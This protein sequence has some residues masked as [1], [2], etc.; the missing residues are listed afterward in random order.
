MIRNNFKIARRN[1]WK[2]KPSTFINLVGLTVGITSCLLIALFIQHE[3]SY[4]SFQPNA[5]RIARLVM[6]Y[7][8]EGSPETEIGT[9]TSTKV[10]PVFSRTF[11]EVEKGIRM[12][13]SSPIV[14]LK[15]EPVTEPGFLYVDST[16]FDAFYY[17]L[18]QGNS[19]TALDGPKKVLLTESMAVKYF[20]DEN[21]IG[22][23]LELGEK[24]TP[25]EI[26]GIL[27][28]YP[29]NS[30]FRFDF[31]ASFSSLNANQ[32]ATYFNANYTTYLLLQ[33]ESSFATLEEKIPAFMAKETAGSGTTI[34]FYLEHFDRVH[35]HSPYNDLVP[36]TSIRYLM[37]L[38]SVALLILIIVCA[39]YINL[40]TA[41][42]MERAKEVGVRKVSGAV[43]SQLFWQFIGESLLLSL[44]AVLVSFGLVYLLLPFFNAFLQKDLL[45]TSLLTPS[46][47]GFSLVVIGAISLAAGGYPALILSRLQPSH[48]LKGAF[49]N[50][51]T[52]KWLQQS[53]TVFQFSI[54]VFLIVTTLIV[55]SQLEFIQSKDLGYDRSH[56]LSI[57]IGRNVSLEKI[58]LLKNE[59]KSNTQILE[60]SRTGSSPVNIISGY[61]MR[62]PSAPEN[63]EIPVNANPV[64][65]HYLQVNGLE[66]I[67]GTNFTR[68]QMQQVAVAKW[69]DRVIHYILTESAANKLGWTAE[70][71][72]GKDMVLNVPGEV[73]GVIKDFHF[74]SLRDEI[75]PLVLFTGVF[76]NKLLVKVNGEDMASAISFMADK[77]KELVPER[78]F[79]YQFLDEDYNQLY[80][81]ETQLGKIMNLFSVV[82]IVLA[83]LGL[84][85]LSSYMIQQRMKEVS[86]RK[87][88]GASAFQILTI[89]S[90]KFVGLVFVAILIA[91]PVAYWLMQNWL[92]GFAF[93]IPMPW[94]TFMASAIL[95]L[96]IAIL[97]AGIHGL[98]ATLD[99]P[100]NSLKSE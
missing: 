68:R 73:V 14:Q 6:E 38:G 84:F 33:N 32:E 86:I 36:N 24:K 62:L 30:Q 13:D 21:P 69:E 52:A 98:K 22:K 76:G 43:R 29:S 57:P 95:T 97:T 23:S 10:A 1:L 79:L 8:F 35:L 11:P 15:G 65:E 7:S 81:T 34:N 46:L 74:Q 85:G 59:F 60:V 87:I 77:W 92:N 44:L 99:N 58:D 49:K 51:P 19:S 89:L 88:M 72:I 18:I 3:S 12:T 17:E 2:N 31:L 37:I 47:L 50:T 55:Q 94:W 70:E 16:F 80:Q 48:V 67:A 75:Q 40:S 78:P 28:D 39:T 90:G 82:A 41:K 64:D 27:K 53:L 56:V 42:S 100:V 20:G 25:Y 5:D 26:T 91:S 9:F 61:S 93:H 66:L 63:E 45:Y 54:S 96:L 83:C 71:A 4:D